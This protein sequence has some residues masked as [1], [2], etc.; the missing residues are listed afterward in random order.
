MAAPYSPPSPDLL[1]APAP[2]TP[3][4]NAPTGVP[5]PAP[6]TQRRMTIYYQDGNTSP[7]APAIDVGIDIASTIKDRYAEYVNDRTQIN[8]IPIATKPVVEVGYGDSS[9]TEPAQQKHIDFVPNAKNEF[10]SKPTTFPNQ[11]VNTDKLG[12]HDTDVPTSRIFQLKSYES[13]IN[14]PSS[15]E[16]K[17]IID[18]LLLTTRGH[19]QDNP[20]YSSTINTEKDPD[21]K[22]VL[23]NLYYKSLGA[24]ATGSY[25]KPTPDG[26]TMTST[27]PLTIQQ[28]Q[29]IGLNIMFEAVQGQAGLGYA[30]D[31]S[32]PSSI[33]EAEARMV[34]PSEQRIG[35][36]V[37]LGR[38]TPTFQLS[39]LTKAEKPKTDGFIDNTDDLQ[40]YGNLYNAYSQFDSLI[41]IGQIALAVAMILA[42]VALL[43]LVVVIIKGLNKTGPFTDEVANFTNLNNSEKKRLLGASV[44]QNSGIYPLSET[45]AED[46]ALQFLG[47]NG[48]LTNTR[49]DAEVSINAGIQ[50]FFGFSFAPGALGST[51]TIQQLANS[52]LKVLTESGRLNVILREV[53]RSGISLVEDTSVD[54]SSGASVAGIG[55]LIRKIRDLK[56]VRFINV[57]MAMGDKVS[58]ENELK[59]AAAGNQNISNGASYDI[60]GSNISY[61]DSLPDARPYYIS[62]NRLSNQSGLAWSNYTA[63]M[64]ELPLAT[65]TLD[66]KSFTLAGSNG[67]PWVDAGINLGPPSSFSTLG[68]DDRQTN[69]AMQNDRLPADVVEAMEQT[70]E[71]DYMPFYIHDLRTNEILSFHAFLE[72]ASEDFSVEYT[73][74][75]GYGRMDKVQIYKGTSRTINVSF[76]MIAT[77]EMDHDIMWYKINKLATMIYPQWT[78][79]RKIEAENIKFIQPFSQI[80][81]ATPVIRLRLGDLYKTNFS[82]MAVTRLFGITTNPDYNVTGNRNNQTTATGNNT[83]ATSANAPTPAS[84]TGS[85]SQQSSSQR[86][87]K[88]LENRPFGSTTHDQMAIVNR[89]GQHRSLPATYSPADIFVPDDQI[90][91]FSNHFPHISRYQISSDGSRIPTTINTGRIIAKVNAIHRGSSR[92]RSSVPGPITG[93][94]VTP[95][96]YVYDIT[97]GTTGQQGTY[98]SI[99]NTGSNIGAATTATNL[100]VNSVVLTLSQLNNHNSVIDRVY[101]SRL[102]QQ[103]SRNENSSSQQQQPQDVNSQLS[104]LNAS[105]FYDDNNNPIMKAF[106]SSGGK[107]L[108]GVITNFKIDYGESKGNWGLDGSSFLRA[109]MFVTI[110]LGMSVIHDITPGLDA[111][112]IMLAPVWPVGNSSNYFINNGSSTLTNPPNQPTPESGQP[113]TAAVAEND[114][115]DPSKKVLYINRKD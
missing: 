23:G 34:I 63:G 38:F 50:E 85:E 79:G 27:G 61:V 89:R 57:L 6:P 105:V 9:N 4:T 80:P 28:L 102:M 91:L 52:S 66:P 104:A 68:L 17:Q 72:D 114:Y 83:N 87:F 8:N 112:G 26:A 29:N 2:E 98:A 100:S 101:T 43:D 31:A 60:T 67:D 69:D 97:Q 56:I 55:N 103:S 96:R 84:G 92:G 22:F 47:V 109:P 41:S 11:L 46:I 90:V 65:A 64:I 5:N 93:I 62:K 76:K 30:V 49:H 77:G 37:S 51:G 115:F 108:A 3:G 78:Q 36:R 42:Y 110:N 54:F 12:E 59:T 35:K 48:L 33:A 74:A 99:I 70:L 106:K 75:E 73:S 45:G 19:N 107:G 14:V 94:E 86:A 82:K 24:Y 95:L 81:G 44:L 32:N 58:F 40:T 111:K 88:L 20:L 25:V 18:K 39:K 113:S 71:S 1:I 16:H 13:A 15:V 10:I 21:K 53:I 7:V